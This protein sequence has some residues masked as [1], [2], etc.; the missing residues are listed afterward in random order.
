MAEQTS[1]PESTIRS[2]R[3]TRSTRSDR[4]D[5]SNQKAD[6]QRETSRDSSGPSKAARKPSGKSSGSTLSAVKKSRKVSQKSNDHAAST[7][8]LDSLFSKSA[9]SKS[10]L[11]SSVALWMKS[12][13]KFNRSLQSYR[14]SLNKLQSK[15]LRRAKKNI[16]NYP[17]ASVFGG[18]TMGVLA[19]MSLGSLFYSKSSKSLSKSNAI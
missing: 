17:F 4:S 16:R 18:L 10:A 3:S 6:G 8:S 12:S 11:D 5:R 19:G 13:K 15:T 7:F 9:F 1:S 14:R 2:T